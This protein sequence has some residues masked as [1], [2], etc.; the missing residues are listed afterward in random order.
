MDNLSLS[1]SSPVGFRLNLNTVPM[2]I[3]STEDGWESLGPGSKPYPKHEG[4]SQV[5]EMAQ[6]AKFFS[7]FTHQAG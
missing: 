4:H 1:L 7:P 5:N 3:K 2:E 6:W